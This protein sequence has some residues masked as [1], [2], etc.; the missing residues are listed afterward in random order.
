MDVLRSVFNEVKQTWSTGIGIGVLGG[1]LNGLVWR[2]ADDIGSTKIV[3]TI[4]QAPQGLS[5]INHVIANPLEYVLPGVMF[6]SVKAV[7][8]VCKPSPMVDVD[9]RETGKA[10]TTAAVFSLMPTALDATGVMP[11]WLTSELADEVLYGA[12]LAASAEAVRHAGLKNLS[13]GASF[14]I[15]LIGGTASVAYFANRT[16]N[17]QTTYTTY[18]ELVGAMAASGLTNA[19]NNQI[20]K[21]LFPLVVEQNNPNALTER[22]IVII[23]ESD[24]LDVDASQHKELFLFYMEYP[25]SVVV[26]FSPDKRLPWHYTSDGNTLKSIIGPDGTVA[27]PNGWENHALIIKKAGDS[28]VF[29]KQHR[30]TKNR[31]NLD[32][33]SPLAIAIMKMIAPHAIVQPENMTSLQIA[34][35]FNQPNIIGFRVDKGFLEI[36]VKGKWVVPQLNN[37]PFEELPKPFFEMNFTLTDGEQFK[38][39]TYL[40][41]DL[42]RFIKKFVPNFRDP[43]KNT[44]FMESRSSL[45][46]QNSDNINR[47]LAERKDVKDEG[48]RKSATRRPGELDFLFQTK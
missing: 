19:V 22:N 15:T 20:L 40:P 17:C 7:W 14:F 10:V 18:S 41:D 37:K 31:E 23:E 35:H 8:D 3:Q 26:T 32:N 45:D 48:D 24:D 13:K 33:E 30:E 47:I 2:A 25:N 43:A 46:N 9:W 5:A 28:Y 29:E 11:S 16:V 21:R 12:S 42:T 27:K 6:T 44:R 38:H 39:S 36:R 34:A 1:A 4:C